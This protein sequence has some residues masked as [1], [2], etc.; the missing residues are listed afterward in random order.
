MT[1][2]RV[3]L[4][5]VLRGVGHHQGAGELGRGHLG[6]LERVGRLTLHVLQLQV[7][8]RAHF[9]DRVGEGLAID[10]RHQPRLAAGQH[11]VVV[12]LQHEGQLGAVAADEQSLGL[13]R[14]GGGAGEAF[15][16]RRLVVGPEREGVVVFGDHQQLVGRLE[17]HLVVRV[18]HRLG[19]PLVAGG[20]PVADHHRVFHL[21]LRRAEG[22]AGQ[23]GEA[24]E[25]QL[26][27]LVG[28]E[29]AVHLREAVLPRGLHHH[30][31]E[32]LFHRHH[33]DAARPQLLHHRAPVG[34]DQLDHRV[35]LRQRPGNAP[36]RQ[37]RLDRP[38]VGVGLRARLLH[39]GGE[40]D[41][42]LR[43][44]G[45]HLAQVVHRVGAALPHHHPGGAHVAQP[46]AHGGLDLFLAGG[47]RG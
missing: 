37:E 6:Q 33:L 43:P 10:A 7:L 2:L 3:G 39:V 38:H 45:A 20:P 27:A 42:A 15:G 34:V 4:F 8:Q 24:L 21:P 14:G 26:A 13:A 32:R 18:E 36:Q 11:V 46:L 31:R 5:R 40:H 30:A 9:L 44:P 16:E 25:V 41:D 35:I 19:G 17:H 47:E 1:V 23:L 22:L 28:E 29:V 12:F